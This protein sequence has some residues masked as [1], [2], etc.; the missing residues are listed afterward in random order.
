MGFLK[1]FFGD[2]FHEP[3]RRAT[4]RPMRQVSEAELEAHL[5]RDVYDGFQLTDAV[6]PSYDLTIVPQQGFRHDLFRDE[7]NQLSVPVIMAAADRE[8]LLDLFLD[9]LDPLGSEIDV[10]LETSHQGVGGGHVDLYREAMDMPVLKSTLLDFEDILLDDGC[11]GVA[12]LNPAKRLEVQ[13]DEHK[14]LVVYGEDLQEFEQ[15]LGDHG[16][17]CDEEIRF[18]TEAEHVHSSREEYWKRFQQL[19]T[20]LGVEETY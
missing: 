18:I 9:L 6:R 2:V 13:F 20:R 12:V 14:L 4:P 16:V 3:P 19:R 17:R 15:A 7:E 5:A 10:V 11:T 8:V 1:K